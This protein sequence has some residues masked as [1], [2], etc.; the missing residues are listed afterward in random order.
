MASHTPPSPEPEKPE[1]KLPDEQQRMVQQLFE[2]FQQHMLLPTSTNESSSADI[3]S[4]STITDPVTVKEEMPRPFAGQSQPPVFPQNIVEHPYKPKD[5]RF[6]HN[7]PENPP[8]PVKVDDL[9]PP[10]GYICINVPVMLPPLPES[11]AKDES[12]TKSSPQVATVSPFLS[13]SENIRDLES[14]EAMLPSVAAEDLIG[15][16]AVDV[17]QLIPDA[18]ISGTSSPISIKPDMP[19]LSSENR[20]VRASPGPGL[21][22]A[23]NN[24]DDRKVSILR[25]N[26]EHKPI[27]LTGSPK[28]RRKPRHQKR[29]PGLSSETKDKLEQKLQQKMQE[30]DREKQM[31]VQQMKLQQEQT[32]HEK[33]REKQI[34][35]QQMKLQQEILKQ[36][37]DQ[38]GNQP[39]VTPPAQCSN[40]I[41]DGSDAMKAVQQALTQQLALHQIQQL[42]Q[43]KDERQMELQNKQ[44]LWHQQVESMNDTSSFPHVQVRHSIYSTV[45]L[46]RGL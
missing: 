10:Q 8:V 24:H 3:P 9:V 37:K 45:H 23:N 15:Q 1:M 43:L 29:Y 32:M 6:H 35:V 34:M 17:S 22:A 46:S 21:P 19:S 38:N 14:A 30:K 7:S 26:N 40:I 27:G 16:P 4:S 36:Q 13:P 11:T 39:Q 25:T 42:Q 31:M 20:L 33:D 2:D 12:P 28:L 44:K 5:Y 18:D 41:V